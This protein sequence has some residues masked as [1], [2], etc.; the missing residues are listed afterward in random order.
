MVKKKRNVKLNLLKADDADNDAL[1]VGDILD[2][3]LSLTG[4][5]RRALLELWRPKQSG[6]EK[7]FFLWI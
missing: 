2:L 5:Q 4:C 7:G 1:I 3:E 6:R